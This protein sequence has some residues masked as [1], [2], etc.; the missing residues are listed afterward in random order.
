MND[1]SD[2]SFTFGVLDGI[3]AGKLRVEGFA[4]N[5]TIQAEASVGIDFAN[6]FFAGVSGNLPFATM[7]I[8]YHFSADELPSPSP[9]L[10]Y[11]IFH[12]L[13][14]YERKTT[15]TLSCENPADILVNGNCQGDDNNP[16][17]A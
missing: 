9:Y 5:E 4:G 6:G 14:G 11:F 10:H 3:T 8:D 13:T 2:V 17:S 1:D 12:S 16:I 15:T 7:G